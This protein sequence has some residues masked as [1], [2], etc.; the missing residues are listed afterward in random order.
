M[1]KMK[2]TEL[3]LASDRNGEISH[4]SSGT[5]VTLTTM[6]FSMK[7]NSVSA[8]RKGVTMR[9]L[10]ASLQSRDLG[11]TSCCTQSYL[12]DQM[13]KVSHSVSTDMG[14]VDT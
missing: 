7:L 6:G 3:T 10:P 13:L 11:A 1:P 14:S 9:P 4:L 8:S 5:R 2:G 12:V